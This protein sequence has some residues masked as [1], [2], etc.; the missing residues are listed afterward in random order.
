MVWHV[1]VVVVKRAIQRVVEVLNGSN[2]HEE[3][4]EQPTVD[5]DT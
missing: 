5:E 1:E 2:V 3:H 4:D